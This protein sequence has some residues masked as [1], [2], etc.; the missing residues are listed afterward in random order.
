MLLLF[1]LLWIVA[2][3]RHVRPS[4]GLL[5]GHGVFLLVVAA[6]APSSSAW[7]RASAA[8]QTLLGTRGLLHARL[9]RPVRATRL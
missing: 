9:G 7:A 5:G 3:C 8:S 4:Q 1:C 2:D 6:V